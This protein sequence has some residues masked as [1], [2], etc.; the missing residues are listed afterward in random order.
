MTIL[1]VSTLNMIGDE[2]CGE[3]F[4]QVDWRRAPL[5]EHPHPD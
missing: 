2:V 5:W 1:T 3:E 4:T